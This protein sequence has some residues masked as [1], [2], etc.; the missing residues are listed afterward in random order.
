MRYLVSLAFRDTVR[1]DCKDIPDE[2][3][4]VEDYSSRK[5]DF[6]V[7]AFEVLR[8]E[9]YLGLSFL[10]ARQLNNFR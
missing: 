6:K 9:S 2:R 10:D 1:T 4:V 3:F 5:E 8:R 7:L